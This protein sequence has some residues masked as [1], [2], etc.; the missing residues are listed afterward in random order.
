MRLR[1][2]VWITVAAGLLFSVP[3]AAQQ[4][5]LVTQDPEVVGAGVMLIEGGIDYGRDIFYPWT[6]LKGNLWR[7]PPNQLW[8]AAS[9]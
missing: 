2:L 8:T 3:A 9:P 5:P 7:I 6:G 1:G 4:R